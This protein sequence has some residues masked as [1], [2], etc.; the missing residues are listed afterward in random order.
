[1]SRKKKLLAAMEENPRGWRYDQVARI[2]EDHG[3]TTDSTGGS[4]RTFDHPSGERV[5]LVDAGSG[6]L[7]PV[8]VRNAMKAIS[9]TKGAV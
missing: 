5:G 6:T 8:Y 1:M 7:L 3:F 9:R 2:L 4:H